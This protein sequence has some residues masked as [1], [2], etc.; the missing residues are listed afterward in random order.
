M[1]PWSQCTFPLFNNFESSLTLYL[2]LL[3]LIKNIYGRNPT[4]FARTK[5]TNCSFFSLDIFLHRPT[6]FSILYWSFASGAISD[7]QIFL[8]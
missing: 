1:P 3:L 5:P 8:C 4:Y 2:S 7:L 6:F